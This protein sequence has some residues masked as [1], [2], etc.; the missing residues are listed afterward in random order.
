MTDIR[1]IRMAVVCLLLC[2][3]A[4]QA[5]TITAGQWIQLNFTDGWTPEPPHVGTW[6]NF[7]FFITHNSSD[8]SLPGGSTTNTVTYPTNALIDSTGAAVDGSVSSADW[9]GRAPAA[10][11]WTGAGETTPS[12][13]STWSNE[14]YVNYF[15]GRG[16]ETV[17]IGD[18][19]PNL[20]YHVY[21][22]SLQGA[23][24]LNID[25]NG[26]V[27]GPY[28][29]AERLGFTPAPYTPY[30]FSNVLLNASDQ[31][32]VTFDS[33]TP[34]VN[35]I[36]LEG[37]AWSLTLAASPV[38]IVEGN[39]GSTTAVFRVELSH[40]HTAEVAFTYS[41]IDGSA[42]APDDYVAVS[43]QATIPIGETVCEI[44]VSIVGDTNDEPDE[45]FTLSIDT[46]GSV[47]MLRNTA[48]AVILSDER[49]TYLTPSTVVADSVSNRLFVAHESANHLS[50]VDLDTDT[51]L[52]MIPLPDSPTGLTLSPDA[53]VL[54]VT[55]GVASGTLHTVDTET[56]EITSS[57]AVGHSPRAPVCASSN[58]LSLCNQFE[59]AVSVV[60]PSAGTV[61]ARVPVRREPFAAALTPDGATLLVANLLPHQAATDTNVAA[62]VSVI[63]T[64][65]NTV[66]Q[67][68]A[69]PP[70]SHSLRDIAVSPDGGYACVTHVLSRYRVP[71]TQLLR[72]W[73]NTAALSIIDIAS[74][75]RLNTVLLDDLDLGAANPW[76][77]AFAA[78]GSRLCVTHAGS[79]DLSVIDWPAL[80]ARLASEAD[81][82][83]SSL[84]WLVG[85]RRRLPL[86]GKG[87]R[88]VAVVDGKAYA[89]QA[90][91]DS[92]AIARLDPGMENDTVELPLGWQKPMTQERYGKFSFHDGSLSV[93]SWHS[94]A[95]CHPAVRADGLNWDVLNDGF[96]NA[97]N[98]KSLLFAHETPPTTITGI[99]PNAETSVMAGLRYI[100]FA[101]HSNDEHLAID[102][103]L[104]SLRPTPS[105]ELESGGLSAAAQRGEALFTSASC[106]HCHSGP[107]LTDTSLHDVGTGSGREAGTRF[108]TPTLIEVWRTA[109]YL[110]D[111]RAATLREVLTTFNP[112][113]QH[114]STSG[115]TSQQLDDLEAYLK[116][117]ISGF[118]NE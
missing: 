58:R 45:Y 59:N 60:D 84:T 56:L 102:L 97:K 66:T 96:G 53:G 18:L 57:M 40:A 49:S 8:R 21:V 118:P 48:R 26:S 114:G 106:I 50:V 15:W 43:N 72:G 82:V 5:A 3:S 116:S 54:Y 36:V 75:T 81:D 112:G 86:P 37:T 23:D 105:P 13:D 107:Y 99:R 73:I 71:T 10:T 38:Q 80:V 98:T 113:N 87:P 17:T 77:L 20:R 90:F 76:G 88:G 103:F 100:H 7:N 41:T 29:A 78:D 16:G 115:L 104:K 32:V 34:V 91:S 42:M 11:T 9:D 46:A 117:A 25:V 4:V 89:A 52:D 30:V 93:Q 85:L 109:P 61:L 28:S 79:H 68:V 95:S 65:S 2:G 110:Y 31:L 27:I 63:D 44:P 51:L 62:A 94:C 22:Y 108:D 64:A 14:E 47:T 67:H 24:D 35:A 74:L 69:L 55:T 39:T 33:V 12:G 83:S 70:G 111:G 6:D 1:C 92:L 101:N 19:N